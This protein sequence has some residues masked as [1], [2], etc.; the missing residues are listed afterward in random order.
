MKCLLKKMLF[1]SIMERYRGLHQKTMKI[2]RKQMPEKNTDI[3]TADQ[4]QVLEGLEPVRERPGMYIGNTGLRGL[5]HLVYEVVDLSLIHISEPT[6][7]T[8]ISY[9]VFCLKKKKYNSYKTK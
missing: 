5:H 7:R 1:I 3:Y 8:P 9:A 6:R 4:I 2:R